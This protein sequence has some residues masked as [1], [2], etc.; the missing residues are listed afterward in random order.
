MTLGLFSARSPPP[1]APTPVQELFELL[2]SSPVALVVTI[3]IGAS[4]A[5]F[6]TRFTGFVLNS[7]EA[8]VDRKLAEADARRR[9]YRHE[10]TSLTF[11]ALKSVAMADGVFHPTERSCLEESARQLSVK[12]P[13]LD[14]LV[15]I[16]PR[17]LSK[18]VLGQ[19]PEKCA[20]L[21][22]LLSHFSLID[23]E[24]HP[25]EFKLVVRAPPTTVTRPLSL[26]CCSALGARLRETLRFRALANVRV[27]SQEQFA[28]AFQVEPSTLRALRESVMKDHQKCE[29]A[30]NKS[31]RPDLSKNGSAVLMCSQDFFYT[32][33]KL[34]HR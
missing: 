8:E 32:L 27:P 12:C 1:P 6:L 5:K 19:E 3:I 26:S 13:D 4:L 34:C 10:I 15:P 7:K 21:L 17:A 20:L 24:A 25:E 31:G 14:S 23:G 18:S 11:R 30:L 28:A 2:L 33:T 22:S 9:K 29:L 16:S